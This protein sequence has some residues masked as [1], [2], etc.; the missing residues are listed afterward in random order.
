MQFTDS[1]GTLVGTS[2][3]G[4]HVKEFYRLFVLP[5]T[6][7]RAESLDVEK[8]DT[9]SVLVWCLQPTLFVAKSY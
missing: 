1:V 8:L 4:Y 7:V 3:L 9:S 5:H 6:T 2:T